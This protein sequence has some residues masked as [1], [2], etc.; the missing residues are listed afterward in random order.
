MTTT[1]KRFKGTLSLSNVEDAAPVKRAGTNIDEFVNLLADSW[2]RKKENAKALA[3]DP[4]AKVPFP[5]VAK[6]ATIPSDAAT[7]TSTRFRQ[8][9]EELGIGVSIRIIE[10]DTNEGRDFGLTAGQAKIVVEAREKKAS[11]GRPKKTPAAT[12]AAG[13]GL[14][15]VNAKKGGK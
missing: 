6:M 4:Q 5:N 3:N 10:A 9:A 15:A 2:E 7:L 8:A 1:R 11:G 13:K 14:P 12:P